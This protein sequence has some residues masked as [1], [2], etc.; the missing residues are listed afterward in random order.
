MRHIFSLLSVIESLKWTK[1]YFLFHIYKM[2]EN[3]TLKKSPIYI[4]ILNGLVFV[5][6]SSLYSLRSFGKPLKLFHLYFSSF[7][8]GKATKQ[9]SK[10]IVTVSV[11]FTKL[12]VRVRE[13][14]VPTVENCYLPS[15]K[16][17]LLLSVATQT[18]NVSYHFTV[19]YKQPKKKKK[20]N[21]L[22]IGSFHLHDFTQ[23]TVIIQV[24]IRNH[25]SESNDVKS[26][27]WIYSI[28]IR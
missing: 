11:T 7:H 6:I 28:R 21:P 1:F 16:E 17:F 2:H 19:I 22:I 25:I 26:S 27:H 23:Q 13:K 20:K 15:Y 4:L 9:F 8:F 24:T 18:S 10:W 12:F 3:G 14:M 5:V